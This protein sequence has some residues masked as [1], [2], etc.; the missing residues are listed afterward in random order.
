MKDVKVVFMGTPAFS[1]PVL[2]GLIDTCTVIGV[3]CQP[4]RNGNKIS[5][6]K[7][8]ALAKNIPLFQPEN[9]KTNYQD[10]LNLVPDII[11]TCAY[12]QII[13]KEI[14]DAP[15]YGCVN[16]HASLLP[17][18]RGGAPIHRAIMNGES[19][20]GITIMYMNERMDA[21]SIIRQKEVDILSSDNVG[22]LHERLSILGRNL[23]IATLPDIISGNVEPVKQI[24]SEAT[25]ASTI[26]RED[27]HINFS[28][29]S[30]EV[31]NTIRALNPWPGAYCILENK[32]LK[33]WN[34]RMGDGVF[35]NNFEGEIVNLYEDGIGIKTI[36]GEIVLTEVQLEGHKR[37][38]TRDFLNGLRNKELLMGKICE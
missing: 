35:S 29:T 22:I 30:R 36:N 9:I 13:P 17:K 15:R 32:V 6:I 27:E 38:S 37:M 25:F 19:K 1:V 28:K 31:Y 4:D 26:K 11:I 8:I 14:L 20:T 3:V 23:L 24:E 5:P 12:G 2:N 34:S 16:I 33:V 7:E 21:G 18:Y 10:I